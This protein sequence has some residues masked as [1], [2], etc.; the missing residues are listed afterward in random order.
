MQSFISKEMETM[1]SRLNNQEATEHSLLEKVSVLAGKLITL[2]S[3]L[4]YATI[5]DCRTGKR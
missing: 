1:R 2:F 5:L 4:N 3:K